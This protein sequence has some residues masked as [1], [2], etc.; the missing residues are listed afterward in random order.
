L[1]VALGEKYAKPILK[2]LDETQA[3]IS[4]KA[5]VATN[6]KTFARIETAKAVDQRN[7][8]S[9]I[10]QLKEADPLQAVKTAL[11]KFTGED[12]ASR[13]ARKRM[14]T[15]ISRSFLAVLGVQSKRS[16]PCA[17]TPPV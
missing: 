11:R 7:A 17:L 12:A 10:Q 13:L 15:P 6:S 8:D 9:V 4:L 1:V 14:Y 5:D 16:F 2:Q 3:A